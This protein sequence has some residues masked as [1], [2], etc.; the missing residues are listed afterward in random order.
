MINFPRREKTEKNPE[1]TVTHAMED[2][3]TFIRS[4]K[5]SLI[6]TACETLFT[7]YWTFE[8]EMKNR[9]CRLIFSEIFTQVERDLFGESNSPH[10]NL[11]TYYLNALQ[12]KPALKKNFHA[13]FALLG[14]SRIVLNHFVIHKVP[15]PKVDIQIFLEKIQ[16]IFDYTLISLVERWNEIYLSLREKDLQLIDELNLV[17]NDLQKQLDV[18]YQIIKES[19]IGAANCDKNMNVTHWNPMA[20]RLTGY[21]PGDIIKTSIF[22]IFTRASQLQ[23]K[24]KL[25]SGKKKISNQRLYI[26]PKIGNPFPVL[27]SISQLR[28]PGLGNI[29]YVFNFQESGNN[30]SL[31]RSKQKLHQLATITRL[32]SAIMHDIRNPLNSIGLNM[33]IMENALDSG[34]QESEPKIRQLLRLVQGE[35]QNLT[36]NLNQY[37]AYGQLSELYLEPLNFTEKFLIFME[38]IKLEAVLRKLKIEFHST[39]HPERILG[40]WVQLGRVFRNLFQNAFDASTEGGVIEV[41]QSQRANRVLVSIRDYGH[42]I[43]ESYRKKIFEPFYTTKSAGTGLGLFIAHEIM[44][45]HGGR[46]SYRP[47]KSGGTIFTIS[48]K[49]HHPSLEIKNGKN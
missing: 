32:T 16:K 6:D 33:E 47:A 23:L 38:E 44:A 24:T 22:K 21:S 25:S 10:F 15:D 18:I 28:Y 19:P 30:A 46:I 29:H 48:F 3:E 41:K 31:E 11:T 13:Q 45:A 14:V 2:L 5:V 1:F 37:M 40:D 43:P 42:G 8:S 34:P 27:L 9:D 17:K 7:S 20:V 39:N 12:N 36:Q 4:H 35:I 26:Q 49:V